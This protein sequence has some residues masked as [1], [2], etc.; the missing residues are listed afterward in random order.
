M[1]V[2]SKLKKE[3]IKR[4]ESTSD[5]NLIALLD[6]IKELEGKSKKEKI[7][8]F[9]GIWKDM[10]DDLFDDLTTN[11]HKKRSKDIRQ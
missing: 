7:L 1:T 2:R 4:I 11:L 9:A 6:F 10:D 3:I 5:E 8:S